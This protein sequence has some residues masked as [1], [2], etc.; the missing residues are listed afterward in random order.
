MWWYGVKEVVWGRMVDYA[1]YH[2]G[3]PLGLAIAALVLSIVLPLLRV[4]LAKML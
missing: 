2:P 4:F 3:L 1:F